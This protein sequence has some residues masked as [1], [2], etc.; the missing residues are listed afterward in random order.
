VGKVSLLSIEEGIGKLRAG[1]GARQDP[2]LAIV[3]RTSAISV[4]GLDDAIARG[5]AYEA[6]GV[7][8][9]FFSGVKKRAELD[10]LFSAI[11]L[12]MILGNPGPE[13]V[14]LEYLATRRV[15][16]CL[17]GHTP[18]MAATQAVYNTLKALRDGVAPAQLSAIASN[19]LMQSFTRGADYDEMMRSFLQSPATP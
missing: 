7:D 5:Q 13:V 15:K 11:S 16:I 14:D 10:A 8:A 17:Q 4:T 3:G 18:I 12:P 6:A 1:L 19:E 2:A 9:M